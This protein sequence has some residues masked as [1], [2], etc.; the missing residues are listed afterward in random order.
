M[1]RNIMKTIVIEQALECLSVRRG[2]Y[3]KMYGDGGPTWVVIQPLQLGGTV[4]VPPVVVLNT[5]KANNAGAISETTSNVAFD[6]C[7]ATTTDSGVMQHTL[8]TY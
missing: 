5:A 2:A 7:N 6:A 8:T 3:G 4:E 1:Q